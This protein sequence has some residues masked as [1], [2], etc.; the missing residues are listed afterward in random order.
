MIGL[1]HAGWKSLELGI[2]ENLFAT[3][4]KR[5]APT[6]ISIVLGIGIC[7][8]C[9]RFPLNSDHPL[10]HN[11]AWNFYKMHY[12][13]G[14]VGIDLYGFILDRLKQAGIPK[15]NISLSQEICSFHTKNLEGHS[16]FFSHRRASINGNEQA[17][18]E[19]RFVVFVRLPKS[20]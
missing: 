18:K 13:D 11:P 12:P 4:D 14:Y 6:D 16:T 15:T 1:V 8:N 20:E 5:I 17:Q 9:Y 2:I 19:G 7:K 10:I 3:I